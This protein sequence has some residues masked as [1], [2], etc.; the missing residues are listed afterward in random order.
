[1]ATFQDK[2]LKI[3]IQA[4][5]YFT[6]HYANKSEDGKVLIWPAQVR[7]SAVRSQ[8]FGVD[9]CDCLRVSQ[10]LE[11]YWC[12]WTNGVGYTNCCENDSPTVS[13]I[14]AVLSGVCVC[15]HS[16]SPVRMC[17][18]SRARMYW[19][20]LLALPESLTTAAQRQEWKV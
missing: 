16:C 4:A 2:Y 9:V 12:G 1:M 14:Q 10:V 15:V 18:H 17:V 3:P 13:A 7:C 6:Q 19:T 20:G 8:Y 11:T 5:N